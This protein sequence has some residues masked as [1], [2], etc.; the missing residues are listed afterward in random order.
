MR[1]DVEVLAEAVEMLVEVHYSDAG[2]LGS[3]GNSQ[4][5]QR[6]AMS[7]M[8]AVGGE[9]THCCEHR[10]LHGAVYGNLP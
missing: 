9:L 4:I 5:G 7:A 8:G 10:T 1:F 3:C 6:E 2:A